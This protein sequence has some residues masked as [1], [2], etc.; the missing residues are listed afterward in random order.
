MKKAEMQWS[1][2]MITENGEITTQSFNAHKTIQHLI[3]V[4]NEMQEEIETLQ[5]KTNK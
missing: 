5:A 3:E 4:I 2:N 1:T